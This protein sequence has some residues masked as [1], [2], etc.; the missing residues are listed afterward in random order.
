MNDNDD[1]K[2][3]FAFLAIIIVSIVIGAT[4]AEIAKIKANS[5]ECT[6]TE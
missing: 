2:Y 6:A 5:V 3:A 4:A 1:I